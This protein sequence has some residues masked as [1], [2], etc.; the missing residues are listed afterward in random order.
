MKKPWVDAPR[1]LLWVEYIGN[2]S[3][4]KASRVHP[5]LRMDTLIQIQPIQ[6]QD[7]VFSSLAA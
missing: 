7:M 3:K 5:L 1:Q 2:L 4:N 6:M